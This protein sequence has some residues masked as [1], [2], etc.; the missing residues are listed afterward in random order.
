MGLFL[1]GIIA[2]ALNLSGFNF[3]LSVAVLLAF[4]LLLDGFTQLFNIRKGNNLLRL[5]TGFLFGLSMNYI[6]VWI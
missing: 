1:G 2:S 4:P 3:P 6:G 5:V